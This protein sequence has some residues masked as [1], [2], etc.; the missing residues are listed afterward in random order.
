MTLKLLRPTK[1]ILAL[2]LMGLVTACASQGP[3]DNA[4]ERK[5]SWFSYL[6][7][8]DIRATCGPGADDRYRLVYNGV[9]T[10]QVRTYDLDA[11]GQPGEHLGGQ[12]D[13]RVIAPVNLSEV[14]I[15]SLSDLLSPWRGKTASV[16][17][18]PSAFEKIEEAL[19]LDGVFGPPAVGTELSSKGFFWTIAACHQ[20]RYHFTAVAWPSP[21]WEVMSFDDVLFALDPVA[22]AINP[23]RKT[24][25]G[26]N[27]VRPVERNHEVEFHTKV[28]ENGL[29][30]SNPLGE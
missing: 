22:V 15:S 21:A 18:S 28:G 30:G 11:A 17:L 29:Y 7:G 5:F 20:G 16:P 25:L 24:E 10:E 6:E 27:L 2:S 3:T 1:L 4:L 26:R 13:V 8:R 9:Y 14:H 19:S 23:P 12:L